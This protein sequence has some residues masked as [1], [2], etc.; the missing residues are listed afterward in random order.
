MALRLFVR[1]M[2]QYSYRRTFSYLSIKSAIVIRIKKLAHNGHGRRILAALRLC[3]LNRRAQTRIL[4]FSTLLPSEVLLD[5]TRGSKTRVCSVYI[6]SACFNFQP[7]RLIIN[8]IQDTRGEKEYYMYKPSLLS[9]IYLYT[10]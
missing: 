8:R 5:L 7:R 9:N 6:V 3:L 1:G 2:R 10:I 4:T